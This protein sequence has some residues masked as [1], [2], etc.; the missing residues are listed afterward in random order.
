MQ[1]VSVAPGKNMVYFCLPSRMQTWTTVPEA[2]V[3]D[4][5]LATGSTRGCTY[6]KWALFKCSTCSADVDIQGK[7]GGD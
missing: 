7:Q 1:Q 2:G 4:S 3:G 6:Y 5:R